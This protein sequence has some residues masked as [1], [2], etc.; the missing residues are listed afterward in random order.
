[1]LRNYYLTNK[2]ILTGAAAFLMLLS[3]ACCLWYQNDGIVKYITDILGDVTVLQQIESNA[4]SRDPNTPLLLQSEM[5]IPAGVQVLSESERFDPYK[6][7][8]LNKEGN[9]AF[10]IMPIRS[11][12]SSVSCIAVAWLM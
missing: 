10:H 1:M 6:F 4:R 8:N 3:F 11:L 7:L 12:L 2:W 5:D 9:K